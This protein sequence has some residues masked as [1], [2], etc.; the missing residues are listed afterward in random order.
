MGRAYGG[1]GNEP[2]RMVT[3]TLLTD[4]DYLALARTSAMHVGA[5]LFLPTPRVNDLCLAVDEAC[6]SFLPPIPQGDADAAAPPAAGTME[7]SYDRYPASL[8]VTVRATA[9]PGWP[10]R[11]ELGWAMLGNLVSEIHAILQNGVGAL[12]L[13]EPLPTGAAR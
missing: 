12:T 8:R 11:D 7:L 13:V 2:V 3:L 9:P 1:T 4:Q 10:Q 5:L 6:T